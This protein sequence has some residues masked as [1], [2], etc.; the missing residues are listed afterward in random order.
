MQIL[1]DGLRKLCPD[2][3]VVSEEST[4]AA[5][6][7]R[8]SAE[9]VWLVDPLDGTKEFLKRSGEFAVNLGLCHRGTPIFGIVASPVEDTIY[10]GGT[11]L[12]G[13]WK[14]QANDQKLVGIRCN[15]F[16]WNDAGLK[17][18]ASSSHNSPETKAFISRLQ[19]P[20]LI[21]AG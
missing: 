15:T 5:H 6:E 13:A 7:L 2:C 3:L 4:H 20:S 17:V 11:A 19:E 16:R 14:L 9:F 18:T 8:C 10:L 12:G 21:R 1:M